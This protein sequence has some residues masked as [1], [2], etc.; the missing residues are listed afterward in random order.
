M[1]IMHQAVCSIMHM[2]C[3]STYGMSDELNG[4]CSVLK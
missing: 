2:M 1:A 4:A 3:E